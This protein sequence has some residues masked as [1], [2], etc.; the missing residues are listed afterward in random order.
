M[1]EK[2]RK[3]EINAVG[4]KFAHRIKGTIL[5]IGH[6]H[7]SPQQK[8]LKIVIKAFFKLFFRFYF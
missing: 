7:L 4:G 8:S 1:K 2:K 6:K 5:F 3:Y